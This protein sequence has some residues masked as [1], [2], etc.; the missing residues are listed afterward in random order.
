M[1]FWSWLAHDVL[2]LGHIGLKEMPND[3]PVL[4]AMQSSLGDQ[5]SLYYFPS[6]GLGDNPTSEQK[7]EA[8]KQANEKFAKNPSGLL[9]YNPPGRSFNFGKML[10]T[11]FLAEMVQVILIL[12]LLSKT[13]IVSYGCRVGFFF[14]AGILASFP[15]NISYWN[16]DGF[17]GNYTAAFMTIQI[18][19][20]LLAGIVASL[21][22]GK[23]APQTA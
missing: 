20:F 8:M 17:P 10:F 6:F 4:A 12:V 11:E 21:V 18:V 19:G 3:Q 1:F 23:G 16:W 22:L 5:A 2:P 7:S 9:V 14:L 15:T 13:R